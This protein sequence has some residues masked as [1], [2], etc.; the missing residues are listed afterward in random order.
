MFYIVTLQD[1]IRIHPSAFGGDIKQNAREII[2]HEYE[3]LVLKDIGY[4]VAV[5]DILEIGMGK[6][7]PR[8]EGIFTQTKFQLLIF[9]P[10][11][12][13]IVEGKVVE[14]VDFGVFIRLGPTDGLCHVSQVT[15][16]YINYNSKQSYL[17]GK[18]TSRIL[19]ADDIVRARIVAISSASRNKSGK[20]GLSMRRPFLGKMEWIKED[21][22]GGPKREKK[23]EVKK[24]DAKKGDS[25]K[26]GKRK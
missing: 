21:L 19:K 18:E 15:D 13:E 6:I 11:L 12:N 23:K 17:E 24:K 4:V 25:R 8:E 10:E 14:V 3:D 7:I 2:S 9:R 1:K 22:E 20:L 5:V 16:D 26:K